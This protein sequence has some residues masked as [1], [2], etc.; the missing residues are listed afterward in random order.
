MF[1]VTP[2]LRLSAELTQIVG[3]RVDT[4]D[5]DGRSVTVEARYRF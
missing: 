4:P 1:D 5:P 3:D 2:P